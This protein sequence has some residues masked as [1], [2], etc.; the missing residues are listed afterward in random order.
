M[1]AV[2]LRRRKLG[3]GSCKGMTACHPDQLSFVRNDKLHTV[4]WEGVT[5][6]IRWGCTS[7][8]GIP[9]VQQINTSE[10]IHRVNDKRSFAITMS[11]NMGLKAWDNV[12]D[13]H[14]DGKMIVRPVRHAQGKNVF[15]CNNLQEV[16]RVVSRLPGGYYIRPYVQKVAE[17][18]VYVMCGRVVTV[19]QKT[20]ANPDA[21]A[22]NVAQGGRFDVLRWGLWPDNVC[23]EAVKMFSL[24]GLHFGGVDVMVGEDG[25]AY[26][27]EINSAPSLPALSDGS[28]SYRQ[29][30]MANAF[31]WHLEHGFTSLELSAGT[32]GGYRKYLHPSATQEG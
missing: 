7:E 11:D 25:E 20:P 24:S 17:Y 28:I 18:R 15:L 4:D 8:L 5:H 14:F 23:E 32:E 16:S 26:V 22:W 2:F 27:V 10:A 3:L 6:V 9:G 31:K 13:V 1:K 30:V 21:I 29:K 19:A 12:V